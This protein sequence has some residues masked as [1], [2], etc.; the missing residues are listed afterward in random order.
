M[1][2]V[3][4]QLAV[5]GKLPEQSSEGGREKREGQKTRQHEEHAQ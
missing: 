3:D 4:L 2:L 1:A 5:G